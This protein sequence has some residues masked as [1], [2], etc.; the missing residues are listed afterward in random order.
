[1]LDRCLD[2]CDRLLDTAHPLAGRLR[3]RRL[4]AEVAVIQCLARRLA[5]RLRRA[6]PLARRVALTSGD[7]LAGAAAGLLRLV[8][9]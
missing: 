1:V 3:S 9:P 7:K 2:G 5:S 6:D 4:A 8:R